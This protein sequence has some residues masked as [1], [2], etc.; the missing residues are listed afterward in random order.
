MDDGGFGDNKTPIS[1]LSFFIWLTKTMGYSVDDIQ[2][3]DLSDIVSMSAIESYK[4]YEESNEDNKNNKKGKKK[5]DLFSDD[6][7]EL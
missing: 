7:L 1:S 3:F 4:Y 2:L 6:F 5:I